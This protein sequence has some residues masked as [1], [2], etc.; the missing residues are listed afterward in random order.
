MHCYY[1]YKYIYYILFLTTLYPVISY[2]AIT[3]EK[4]VTL[5]GGS[6]TDSFDYFATLSTTEL[7]FRISE[8]D[9][10]AGV[11]SVS[12]ISW[13][14]MENSLGSCDNDGTVLY[15]VV[16]TGD[17]DPTDLFICKIS[18][19][20]VNCSGSGA[21]SKTP[22]FDFDLD[23]SLAYELSID[24]AQYYAKI[25]DVVK[26]SALKSG[27]GSG[28]GSGNLYE[29]NWGGDNGIL[30][31]PC[32]SNGISISGSDLNN[33]KFI[34]YSSSDFGTYSI[35]ISCPTD[36]SI[37][38]DAE[39]IVPEATF[40]KNL[41]EVDDGIDSEEMIITLDPDVPGAL[42][43]WSWTALKN[44]NHNIGNNP[45][46]DFKNANSDKNIVEQSHWFASP[47]DPCTRSYTSTYEIKV[48]VKYDGR[49][50]AEAISNLNVNVPEMMGITNAIFNIKGAPDAFQENGLW[51]VA[52]IGNLTRDVTAVPEIFVSEDS[53][54]YDAVVAHENI[55]V[56]QAL[57]GING[58]LLADLDRFWADLLQQNYEKN[59][60]EELA[61]Q[62]SNFRRG[63]LLMEQVNWLQM[64][65]CKEE[66]AYEVSDALMNYFHN[67]GRY[68]CK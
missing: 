44:G 50:V 7:K 48:L 63:W 37:T 14:E 30:Y 36:T 43:E 11:N 31:G 60:I 35:S 29:V 42:F 9:V 65:D 33:K 47:D 20:V 46:V 66:P 2:S 64:E 53:Q 22:T 5:T 21:G 52:G 19:T 51:K 15:R 32:D 41:Y 23:G 16:L 56:D 61:H 45:N 34:H 1:I 25:D 12:K 58:V 62:I 18:G 39:H 10:N 59:T 40:D 6:V 13:I 55:H 67:C 24:P 4:S 57:N 3:Q 28:Q 68:T 49:V 27:S 26:Y 38:S 8:D 54:F 17:E